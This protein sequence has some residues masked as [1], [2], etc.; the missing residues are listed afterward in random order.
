MWVTPCSAT[1]SVNAS[2]VLNKGF[3][4]F[5]YLNEGKL[6]SPYEKIPIAEITIENLSYREEILE[7]VYYHIEW[8]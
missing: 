3:T 1:E 5:W 7:K 6:V 4:A 2:W 8:V